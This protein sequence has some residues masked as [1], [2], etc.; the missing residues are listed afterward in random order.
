MQSPP[1]TSRAHLTMQ[2]TSKQECE[3]VCKPQLTMHWMAKQSAQETGTWTH[4]FVGVTG[5]VA[6]A[7]SAVVGPPVAAPGESP[8]L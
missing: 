8:D 1:D 4:M 2:H 5:S 7:G 3:G 6:G